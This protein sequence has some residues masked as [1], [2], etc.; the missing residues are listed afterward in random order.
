MVFSV[1]GPFGTTLPYPCKQFKKKPGYQHHHHTG[2]WGAFSC[3]FSSYHP[4]QYQF[5]QPDPI[6]SETRSNS[7]VLDALGNPHFA[8]GN[9]GRRAPPRDYHLQAKD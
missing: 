6:Q 2:T 3:I 5:L 7:I 4:S 9:S 1:P 8:A